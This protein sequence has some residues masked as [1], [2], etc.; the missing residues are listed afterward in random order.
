VK[1]VV[2]VKL[3][4]LREQASALES[5]LRACNTAAGDAARVARETGVAASGRVTVRQALNHTAG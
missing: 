4:P 2:Q 5:T 3:A 1:L